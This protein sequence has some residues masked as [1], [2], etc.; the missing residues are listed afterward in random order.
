MDSASPKKDGL[1]SESEVARYLRNH[2]GFFLNNEDLLTELKITHKTG[3]A[4]SL[5]ERQVEVLRERNMDMRGRISGMLD[6]AQRND[7]LFE[8]S[9]TLILSLIEDVEPKS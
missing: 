7:M 3:K 1:P 9:K 2:P 4:V 5:L 6:N 8:R